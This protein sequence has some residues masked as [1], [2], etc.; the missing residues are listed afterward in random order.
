MQQ[1]IDNINLCP[2][3]LATDFGMFGNNIQQKRNPIIK[4]EKQSLTQ[5]YFLS[6]GWVSSSL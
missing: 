1:I 3:I 4:I 2:D 6:D 5:K